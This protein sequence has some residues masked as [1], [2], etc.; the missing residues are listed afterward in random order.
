M[1]KE[2]FE[3]N[4]IYEVERDI[5]IVKGKCDLLLREF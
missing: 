5:Y 3:I 1:N 4:I 2:E